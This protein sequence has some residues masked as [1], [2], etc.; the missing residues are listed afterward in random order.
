MPILNKYTLVQVVQHSFF[1]YFLV[2]FHLIF[3]IYILCVFKF[4]CV[5]WFRVKVSYFFFFSY[6]KYSLFCVFCSHL[7]SAFKNFLYL[8][9]FLTCLIH[10]RKLYIFQT[11][12]LFFTKFIVKNCFKTV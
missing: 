6:S 1:F 8:L 5:W 9:F 3:F 12:T 7:Y 4:V 2:S 10:L 11:K